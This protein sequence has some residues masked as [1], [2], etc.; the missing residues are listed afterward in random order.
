M[1]GLSWRVVFD[2]VERAVGA[3]LEDAAASPRYG[4]AVAFWVNG[5]KAVQRNVRRTLDDQLGGVLHA[6]NMPTRGDVARLNRQLA[7]LTAEVR[8]LSHRNP[9]GS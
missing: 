6:L 1:A 3:P 9:D 4:T 5:P 7:V 8:A 2:K